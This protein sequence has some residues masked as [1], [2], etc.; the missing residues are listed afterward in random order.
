MITGSNLTWYIRM[1]PRRGTAG[2]HRKLI[3][4]IW[5]VSFWLFNSRVTAHIC[6]K[7]NTHIHEG[8][9]RKKVDDKPWIIEPWLWQN[10]RT[11]SSSFRATSRER[12]KPRGP[13][14][15]KAGMEKSTTVLSRSYQ[16]P[17]EFFFFFRILNIYDVDLLLRRGSLACT[18]RRRLEARRVKK[19][20]NTASF[21]DI[22]RHMIQKIK[23]FQFKYGLFRI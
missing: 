12:E 7:S 10:G 22:F 8:R 6:N 16:D 14:T 18:E 1:T 20:E 11:T 23:T 9:A 15:T 21:L 2:T 17:H 5:T 4:T 13:R 3:P 19:V